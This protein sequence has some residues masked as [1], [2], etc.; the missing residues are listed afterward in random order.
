MAEESLIIEELAP[1]Y[2]PSDEPH[3]CH[4]CVHA[5]FYPTRKYD[6]DSH[7]WVRKV[8]PCEREIAL[9]LGLLEKSGKTT[10]H[11]TEEQIKKHILNMHMQAFEAVVFCDA[12]NDARDFVN[13]FVNSLAVDGCD[14][15]EEL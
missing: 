15:W 14:W 10:N 9:D 7:S 2:E 8:M 13:E 1:W 4:S 5:H 12:E 3:T 6:F 11:Q